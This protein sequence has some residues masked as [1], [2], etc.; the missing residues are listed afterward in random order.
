[1]DADLDLSK[2]H[3]VHPSEPPAIVRCISSIRPEPDD[4]EVKVTL[5][6]AGIAGSPG[7]YRVI[8]V[9]YDDEGILDYPDLEDDDCEA[10]NTQGIPLGGKLYTTGDQVNWTGVSMPPLLVLEGTM[11]T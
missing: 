4:D 5:L 6:C 1:M 3:C 9:Y 7:E 8:G 11:G 2:Y 10:A